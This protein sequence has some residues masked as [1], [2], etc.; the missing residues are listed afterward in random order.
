MTQ[1]QRLFIR[2]DQI[3][4]GQISLTA[5]QL[6]YLNRVLRLQAGD[7]FIAMNGEGQWWLAV[8]TE[9]ATQAQILESIAA[10]AELP[11]PVTL[12]IAMPKSGLDDVVR[13][14]TELGVTEIVLVSSQRTVLQPSAAKID[15]WQ[16]IVQEAAEQSE[17]QIVPKIYPPQSWA[18]ALQAWNAA[19]STC[20]LCE[21]RGNHP[22]LLTARLP[23]AD[24]RFPVTL[25]IGPEGGWTDGEIELAVAAGYQPVSLGSRILRA[26][27]APMV[28]LAIVA[29]AVEAGR[30]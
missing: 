2:T 10:Q 4:A 14:V 20:Y 18:E 29:S 27:T 30:L 13:Q 6:H 1:L 26:V 15:R 19:N 9:Q 25:A 8:L 17:R 21:A 12:L 23:I 28:A 3:S 16:R 22:H 7:R 5:A 24:S 11:I